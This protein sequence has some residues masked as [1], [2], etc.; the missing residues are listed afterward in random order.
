MSE[1][2]E[3]L[4]WEDIGE[5]PD[6]TDELEQN[7]GDNSSRQAAVRQMHDTAMKVPLEEIFLERKYEQSNFDRNNFFFYK[8]HMELFGATWEKVISKF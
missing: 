5:M 7:D 8:E 1:E 3:K 4:R 2:L 6:Y